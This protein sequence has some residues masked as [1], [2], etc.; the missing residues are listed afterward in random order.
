[1]KIY[2]YWCKGP[3]K[4]WNK[5]KRIETKWNKIERKRNKSV[6]RNEIG[7]VFYTFDWLIAHCWKNTTKHGPFFTPDL[8]DPALTTPWL[9]RLL[10]RKQKP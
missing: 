6:E 9:H 1:M 10:L 2:M 7:G 4:V 8:A 3:C 5:T